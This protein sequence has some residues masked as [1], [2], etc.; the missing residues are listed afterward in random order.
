M[1][2]K[3]LEKCGPN[4]GLE[5]EHQGWCGGNSIQSYFWRDFIEIKLR[6]L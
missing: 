4:L 1:G 3:M 5:H 2:R 6:I